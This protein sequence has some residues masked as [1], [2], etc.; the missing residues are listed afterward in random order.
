[1]KKNWVYLICGVL[2]VCFGCKKSASN[3]TGINIT[4]SGNL[5]SYA[6][7]PVFKSVSKKVFVHYMPWFETKL[8]NGG[9]WGQHWKMANENPEIITNGQRQIASYYYPQ[10]GPYA[11]GDTL[12]IDYQLLLMKLSGIDGVFIDWPGT[13]SNSDWPQNVGNSNVLVSRLAKAGLKYAIVYEDQNLSAIT[14]PL[15][16]SAT[17]MT[18]AQNDMQYIQSNYFKDAGATY[19]MLGGK[20]LLLDFGPFGPLQSSSQWNTIFSVMSTPPSFVTYEY[21]SA[22]GGTNAAGEFAWV[23]ASNLTKLNNF[24]SYGY[25]GAKFS[26]VY[27]GFNN[28]YTAGGWP[29][30]ANFTIAYSSGSTTTFQQTVDLALQQNNNYI[31][32]VTWNDYGEGTMIEP[33][34]QFGYSYLTTLQQKLGVSA[35]VQS[36]LEAVAKLYTARVANISAYNPD[37]LNELDQVYYYMV[38]LKMDS[39]KALLQKDF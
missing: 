5:V 30:N 26:A 25:G 12:V 15:P 14:G 28:F 18:Q 4:W 11:S 37:K 38:S 33:T 19:E 21:Q 2:A 10:I 35:M 8:T 6:P 17:Q 16:L 9:T 13:F 3:Q 39:A 24:Y 34:T 27:P 23:Q 22:K 36:D 20:P 32:V 1:M 31:Q 7:V 29:N